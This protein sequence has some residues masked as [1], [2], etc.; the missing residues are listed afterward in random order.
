MK[1]SFLWKAGACAVAIAALAAVAIGASAGS[2]DHHPAA[3]AATQH[4]TRGQHRAPVRLTPRQ[5]ARARAVAWARSQRGMHEVGTT[6]CSPAIDRWEQH[7]GLAVP[8][9]PPCR[10]WCG[11]FVHEA[12]FQAGIELSDR[13]IDPNQSYWDA[14][15]D[16]NGL[17][18]IRKSEVAP[19]DL[20]FFALHGL[21]VQATH[22][23]IV[24]AP[25]RHGRVV[26][27]GGNVGHHAVVTRRGLRYIVLAARVTRKPTRA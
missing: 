13:V 5:R 7:M 26:T 14:M 23:E 18:R 12:F 6:N 24:L 20:V 22:E 27:A 9:A 10:P 4:A 17:K 11:A 25:P 21:S 15:R 2:P 8:V 19:G 3:A 1:R 16:Q